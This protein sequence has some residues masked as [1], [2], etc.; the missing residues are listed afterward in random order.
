[1][2]N[3]YKCSHCDYLYQRMKQQEETIAQL[4]DM[5]AV[6]NRRIY[7]LDQ[8]QSGIE[9]QLVREHSPRFTPSIPL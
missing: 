8:R 4:V 1:M 9:H 2:K 6:T 3:T 7:D 5:M